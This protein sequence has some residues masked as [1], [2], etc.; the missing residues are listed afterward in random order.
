MLYGIGKD[1]SIAKNSMEAME[2]SGLDWTVS[3]KKISVENVEVPGYIA[4][5]KSDGKVLGVVS[6]QYKIIQNSEA[7]SFAD[8]ITDQIQYETAGSLNNERKVWLVARFHDIDILGQTVENYLVFS[9]CHDGKGSIRITIV[10]VMTRHNN[11]LN[12]P[13]KGSMRSWSTTHYGDINKKMEQA[14]ETLNFSENYLA[15]LVREAEHLA[16]IKISEK[17]KNAFIEKLFPID[18]QGGDRKIDNIKD[19]RQTL[20]NC[21]NKIDFYE[22]TAWQ[23]INGV[24]MLVANIQPKRSSDTFFEKKFNNII[25]GDTLIDKAYKILKVKHVEGK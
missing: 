7:F 9:N 2:I 5:V 21:I 11:P 6:E 18:P 3:S 24:S 13:L 15:D 14:I 8:I 20:S 19:E 4:N 23:L 22:N 17:Q 1:V 10:P 12:I 16:S 25:N